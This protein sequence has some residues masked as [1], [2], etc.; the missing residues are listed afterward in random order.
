[1]KEEMI[2][3]ANCLTKQYGK[4]TALSEVNIAVPQGAIYGLVGNNGAGKSTFLK[5]LAGEIAPTE[6][7]FRM[8]NAETEWELCKVRR[9]TGAI[10]EGPAFYPNMT[11]GQNLEYYRI[12]RGIPGKDVVAK[13]LALVGLEDAVKK[14]FKDMSLGMKQR[15]GL[16]LALMGEPKLLILDEP[17]NGLDPAGI[18]EIRNLLLKLNREKGITIIISSHILAELENIATDYGF[19]NQGKL[20]EQITAEALREKCQSYLEVKVTD[21]S[22]YTSLLEHTFDCRNYKVMPD[23]SVQ[24]YDKIDKVSDYSAL[25]IQNDI[26]LLA[27]EQK[28]IN[29]EKYYMELVGA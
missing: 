26:G 25:A 23:G 19:L 28:E 11:A 2:V 20:V 1:M 3:Q 9:M 13:M 4:M 18:I 16:A 21:V 12:Q 6:G 27:F 5:I 24:I 29:L 10:I 8:M 7:S 22:K 14:K 17:I 15:L